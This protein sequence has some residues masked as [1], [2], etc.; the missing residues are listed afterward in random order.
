MPGT[1]TSYT[2]T[3][4][5]GGPS[6]D[7][8]VAVADTFVA[9]LTGVTWTC[10][11]AGGAS[12]GTASG[13]GNIGTTDDLPDGGS[14]TYT[15]SAN[16]DPC[17]VGTLANTATATSSV[18]DPVVGN[19][20]A[21][22]N[23][24]MTPEV[25]LSVT[26]TD[27]QASDTPGTTTQYTIVASKTGPS[28]EPS[29]T[30]GDTFDP[31]LT[32]VT[33]TCAAAGTATCPSA[34]GSGDLN[35]VADFGENGTLTYT[36][37]ATIDA[38][39]TGTLSNTVTATE[40]G[41][42]TDTDAGNNSA[43]DGTTLVPEADVSVTKTDGQASD[44]PGTST[45]YSITVSNA[46]PSCD[47]SVSFTDNFDANLTGVSWTCA[48]T[49]AAN[50]GSLSGSGDIATTDDLPDGTSVT[51][52]V[53]AD[54]DAC[55]T[56]TL[57]NTATAVTSVTDPDGSNNSSVDT[58]TMTPEVD[59]EITKTDSQ[60]ED[61]P[62]TSTQYTIVASNTGPSC[63]P[64]AVIA[65]TFVADLTDV[66]WTCSATGT[67]VCPS[68]SGNGD[69]SETADLGENGTLT[70]TVDANIAPCAI[71]TLSNTAT[72]TDSAGVTDTDAGNNSATDNTTLTPEVDL[73]ITKTDGQ[74]TDVPGTSTQYT[75]VASTPGR[76]VS[77][78]R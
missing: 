39:A 76:V 25:D 15:V 44:V 58:T 52:T 69:I 70:Y 65:D 51:Y 63:E 6:C 9:D 11:G 73:E 43:T 47:P 75:I 74:A 20:S 59:L 18:T 1:S 35:E 49:G 3:V 33:W 77:R 23:T 24:T 71:G 31:I 2:I 78:Q 16:I 13:S 26:K 60:T 72:V 14:V 61:V 34:S 7:P 42:V 8:A 66:T 29:G 22:D 28:C 68:A 56:G 46:G 36:V 27:S 55:L 30:I 10:A 21:T 62:G 19:N 67:A 48:S 53:T 37:D 12:C 41:G 17:A 4:S 40:S 38:C 45:S 64:S 50:C 54:I 57:T 32:G 5:N